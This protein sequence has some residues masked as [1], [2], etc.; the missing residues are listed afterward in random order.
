M[1]TLTETLHGEIAKIA[2][3]DIHSHVRQLE[4]G[5]SSLRDLLGYHYYIELAWSCG[6]PKSAMAAELPDEKMIP[7]LI[8]TMSKFSNTVQYGWLI[9]MARQYFGFSDRHLTLDNWKPLAQAVAAKVRS[10]GWPTEV[11]R[12]GNIE[13]IFLTNNFSESLDGFDRQTF[14]PCLRCDNLV[15]TLDLKSVRDA[16][17][18][19]SGVNVVD[20]GT[21]RQAFSKVFELFVAHDARSTAISLPPD[22]VCRP[23]TDAAAEHLLAATLRGE[24]L[25]AEQQ[26]MFRSYVLYLLADNCRTFQLPMQLMIG[27]IRD[28]YQHGVTNGTD[29]LSNRGSLVQY[30][31]LFNRF[32]D[33]TFTVSYLSPTMAHELLTMTW[34][35]QNVRASGHWWY[36]NVPGYIEEDLRCR[37]EALPRTK[38]LG[39]YSDAYYVEFAPPKY[40][41]YRWSL[42]RV[43]AAQVEMKRLTEAEALEVARS[44]L[45]DNAKEIF[46]V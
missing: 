45:R 25:T 35:F 4:P 15:F 21:L 23:V 28:G 13:K 9:D 41:M 40:S 18:E 3:I 16:L 5:A 39:Y 12:R 44:V 42:A 34:I 11:L 17:A 33:V 22:F 7:A 38:I 2:A 27:V 6:L 37:I 24:V 1:A 30:L 46:K 14:V 32:P 43:L 8:Q 20:T 29:V 26:A 36:T 19:R 10:P 31:D